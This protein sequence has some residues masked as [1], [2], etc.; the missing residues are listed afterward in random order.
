MSTLKQKTAFIF[1]AIL[2]GLITIGGVVYAGAGHNTTGWGWGGGVAINPASYDGMGWISFNSSDCDTNNDGV[3]DVASCGGGPISNYGVNF[4]SGNGNITG[5][6]W[7]EHYGWI[8]FNGADLAGCVPAMAQAQRVGNALQGGARILAI[9][10]AVAVGNTGGY[11]GCIDLSYATVDTTNS[12]L[13]G[14]FWSSDLGWI[15]VDLVNVGVPTVNLELEETSGVWVN[16]DAG[17]IT[18]KREPS[19]LHLRWGSTDAVSCTTN[20]SASTGISGDEIVAGVGR[21]THVY[22]V[23]CVN[24]N[25]LSQVDQI[26]VIIPTPEANLSL[27][28]CTLPTVPSGS[29]GVNSC[30]ATI[31]WNFVNATL[32]YSVK[33]I[34]TGTE[35][36]NS[37]PNSVLDNLNHGTYRVYAYHNNGTPLSNGVLNI[38]CADAGSGVVVNMTNN[39]SCQAPPLP[40]SITLVPKPDLIRKGNRGIIE[41][42]ITSSEDLTCKVFGSHT[43]PN[44]ATE[45]TSGGDVFYHKGFTSGNPSRTYTITTRELNNTQTVQVECEVDWFQ[46]IK[47]TKT[48]QIG[49][50]GSQQEI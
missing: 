30:D 13:N 32:D 3:V 45:I 27:V 47:T 8:S 18:S 36:Y 1:S 16:G 42:Q 9:R 11:D 22:T 2:L 40:P 5:Q 12:T 15:D 4:P 28:G 39:G 6:A 37:N 46:S 35:Y 7:S 43:P 31:G 23:R 34:D 29:T 21:G 48:T 24:S 20:W 44:H 10:D 33:N 26:T 17:A 41:A 19:D 25:G 49:V 38:V 50:E 14:H